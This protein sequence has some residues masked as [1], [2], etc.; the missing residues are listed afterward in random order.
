MISNATYQNGWLGFHVSSGCLCFWLVFF[1]ICFS[2]LLTQSLLSRLIPGY[3]NFSRV[4]CNQNDNKLYVAKRD[5]SHEH[6]SHNYDVLFLVVFFIV[7]R[8]QLEKFRN[9]FKI[10]R[11]SLRSHSFAFFLNSSCFAASFLLF[12]IH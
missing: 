8:F 2:Q 12:L 1:A 9:I 4:R 5:L 10:S 6:W 3:Q 7:S 11:K